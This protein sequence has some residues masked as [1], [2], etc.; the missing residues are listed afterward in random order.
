MG[1]ATYLFWFVILGNDLLAQGYRYEM[2]K[3]WFRGPEGQI[4]IIT[5]LEKPDRAR[6]QLRNQPQR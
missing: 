2:M 4:V 5:N 6:A 3:G 1:I